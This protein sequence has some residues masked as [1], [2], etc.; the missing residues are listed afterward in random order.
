MISNSI[1]LSNKWRLSVQFLITSLLLMGVLSFAEAAKPTS[2]KSEVT[3]TTNGNAI[4]TNT[5][6]SNAASDAEASAN[7]SAPNAAKMVLKDL[8]EPIPEL[9]ELKQDMLHEKELAVSAPK[10]T[11][12][13]KE[14]PVQL[15]APVKANTGSNL[16]LKLVMT[17]SILGIAGAA[18]YLWA[19]N[20]KRGSTSKNQM[21]QIKILS[22]THLGPKKSLALIRVAGE[23]ILIGV[24]DQNINLIKAL[25]LLDEEVPEEVPNSFNSAFGQMLGNSMHESEDF[26]IAGIKDV[27]QNRL[28]SFR[29]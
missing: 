6:G 21:T 28:K 8:E 7:D 11:R 18:F 5:S 3:A 2:T 26:S 17:V 22:Q 29:G 10:D 9:K 20:Q 23:S 27:V 24:T 16:W 12:S 1:G 25:S 13:E 15:E 19:R 4:A 14:I